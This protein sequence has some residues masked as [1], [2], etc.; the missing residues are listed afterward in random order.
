MTF[1]EMA[2]GV[3]SLLVTRRIFCFCKKWTD[4][5]AKTWKRKN[6]K[7]W[8]IAAGLLGLAYC[9]QQ[10]P[11]TSKKQNHLFIDILK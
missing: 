5:K 10:T 3:V 4:R 8:K 11:W 6:M 1:G 7:S 9:G 2:K